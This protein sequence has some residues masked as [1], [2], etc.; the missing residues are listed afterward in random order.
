MHGSFDK[1]AETAN[2]SYRNWGIG[3]FALPVLIL[4]ALVGLAMTHSDTSGW[5]S[6]AVQAEFTSSNYGPEAVPTQPAK[7]A[8]EARTVK[9]N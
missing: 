3:I 8:T 6:E 2:R 4:I 9:A 5:V 7:P 1:I